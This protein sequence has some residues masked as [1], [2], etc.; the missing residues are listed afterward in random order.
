MAYK[1]ASVN[2]EDRK[3]K[4][5]GIIE[6]LKSGVN[7]VFTSENY[8]E[9][10]RV[11]NL[12]HDYS[13]NN[14]LLIFAQTNGM[15][16]QI[17]GYKTWQSMGRQVRKGEKAIKIFCPIFIKKTEE[18]LLGETEEEQIL[19]S[20]RVGNVFDIKQ[21]DGKEL[22]TLKVEELTDDN[23][24]YD[25]LIEKLIEASPVPV[26]FIESIEGGAKGYY[27]PSKKHIKVLANMSRSQRAKVLVHEIAHSMLDSIEQEKVDEN[28]RE[29]RAESVAFCVCNALGIDTKDYSFNYIAG[30]STGKDG[31]ELKET[32]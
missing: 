19:T 24:S 14:L 21:T 20:F 4:M 13:L 8:A 27:S 18:N 15:A 11:S 2:A 23:P 9:F 12:F 7:E 32:L 30:W 29:V 31:K 16:T 3:E 22:P 6:M 1:K 28:T 10:L 26:E 17:A 5:S 25:S